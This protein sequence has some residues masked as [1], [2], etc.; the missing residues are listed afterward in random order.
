MSP[1]LHFLPKLI[2]HV[3]NPLHTMPSNCLCTLPP[4]RTPYTC[5]CLYA[6][7]N[8]PK[9]NSCSAPCTSYEP[10]CCETNPLLRALQVADVALGSCLPLV[11][12]PYLYNELTQLQTKTVPITC[13]SILTDMT[14]SDC[15][16]ESYYEHAIE[17]QTTLVYVLS[18]HAQQQQLPV[19]NKTSFF[20]LALHQSALQWLCKSLHTTDVSF[21]RTVYN[22]YQKINTILKQLKITI[23]VC[24]MDK[25]AIQYAYT[26]QESNAT[27]M[28]NKIETKER[29]QDCFKDS[30]SSHSTSLYELGQQ[31]SN[32]QN[33]YTQLKYTLLACQ[34]HHTTLKQIQTKYMKVQEQLED[35]LNIACKTYCHYWKQRGC[36]T[37]SLYDC[38]QN[39]V[40]HNQSL[41]LTLQKI[42]TALESIAIHIQDMEMQS[43]FSWDTPPLGVVSHT[44]PSLDAHIQKLANLQM[45]MEHNQNMRDCLSTF[46]TTYFCDTP[47][48]VKSTYLKNVWSNSCDSLKTHLS[49]LRHRI[50]LVEALTVL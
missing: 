29:E 15:T 43:S 42:H 3:S 41:P 1:I 25:N 9:C 28:K 38:L 27:L 44:S 35:I 37:T 10:N 12:A 31:L 13:L 21:L 50:A 8:V 22:V 5:L 47:D 2:K 6:I 16:G 24:N 23:D 17:K 39:I 18:Q 19:F 7:S 20:S 40:V 14:S 49:E 30:F 46:L 4:Q 11:C 26:Q 48:S 32:A 34:T 45:C 36:N 33:E